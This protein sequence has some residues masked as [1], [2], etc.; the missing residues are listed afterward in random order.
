MVFWHAAWLRSVIEDPIDPALPIIDAHHHLWDNPQTRFPPYD[1]YLLPEYLEDIEEGG[2]RIV[3]T[4]FVNCDQMYRRYG[5]EEMRPVGET[6]FVQGI[7]AQ[8][9][10]GQYGT[11]LV[12]AGIVSYADLALGEAVSPVLEAHIEASRNRL[13]GIRYALV[14]NPS[15]HSMAKAGIMSDRKFRDGFAC[16]QKY[17]LSFDAFLFHTQLTEL[18]DLARAFPDIPVIVNHCGSPHNMGPGTGNR[19]AVFE[20]WQ[21]GI[22]ALAACPNVLMKLGGLTRLASGSGE[23]SRPPTSAE[24]AEAMSPYCHFCIEQFGVDRCMFESNFPVDKNSCS[25][26]VLWNAFK[27]VTEGYSPAERS[28]LFHDTTVKAYRLANE[29]GGLIR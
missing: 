8:A 27:R 28:A 16:L 22:R 29:Y 23:I 5:P 4:V 14:W 11:T 20:V 19:E 13:R 2:H 3:Q 9:A 15:A 10:S 7:A 25:Y 18:A 17:G 12:A 1:R 21:R 26:N 24:L 6:E